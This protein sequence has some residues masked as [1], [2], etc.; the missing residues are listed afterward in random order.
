MLKTTLII[1]AIL[2]VFAVAGLAW[3]KHKGYCTGGDYLQRASERISG[4]LDLNDEQ[5]A[6]LQGLTEALRSLREDW[7]ARRTGLNAE[8]GNLLATPTLDRD[9]A[10][11]LLQERHQAMTGHKQGII[12]AFADFSDSL[13]P[14]QRARLAELIADR[15]QHRW[16]Q[17]RWAH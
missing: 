10:M 17:P 7:M 6:K 16:G 13:Q 12:A 8:I 5:N 14:E 3:A 15:M 1:I 9:A 2:G 4:K 11:D